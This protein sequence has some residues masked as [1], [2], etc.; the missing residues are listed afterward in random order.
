MRTRLIS[1][2]TIC[3][4]TLG[5]LGDTTLDGEISNEWVQYWQ[6]DLR[7]IEHELPAIHP[8]A[9]HTLSRE[10]FH[11]RID[12]LVKRVADLS[13]E[14]ILLEL[15]KIVS[16]LGDGHTRVTLPL[17][18]NNGL[19]LGHTQTS[20][21]KVPGLEFAV[22]PIRLVIASD[23]TFVYAAH[24]RY[25]KIV[26]AVVE[27]IGNMTI[28]EAKAA[29]APYVHHDNEYQ[30]NYQL[31]DY[32][33]LPAVLADSGVTQSIGAISLVVRMASGKRVTIEIEPIPAAKA[34]DFI[35]VYSGRSATRPLFAQHNERPFW[36]RVLDEQNALYWQYNE[37]VDADDQKLTEFTD[38]LFSELEARA[39]DKLIIDLRRNRGGNNGRNKQILHHLIRSDMAKTTGRV[40]AITGGGTF[41]A[42]M[43]FSV[44][45]EDNLPVVFVGT[46]T[47]SS[48]NHY[49][50]SRKIQ[51][52]HSGITVRVSTLHWQYSDPRDEREAIHPQIAVD[53][54]V[55]D[56]RNGHDPQL[57]AILTSK[58]SDDLLGEWGG[59]IAYR[60]NYALT[61]A[62]EQQ[63]DGPAASISIPDFGIDNAPLTDLIIDGNALTAKLEIDRESLPL[64]ARIAGDMLYGGLYDEY[65]YLPVVLQRIP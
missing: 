44:D 35:D 65:R 10:E 49:G 57:A 47:G 4:V 59:S 32:L 61:L 41:S 16:A 30:L 23:G 21:P 11:R 48:P 12:G 56:Y 54:T 9:F 40:F 14:A 25:A 63:A 52:P 19:F 42:A 55:D 20:A 27:R 18:E 50:D 8:N 43:M 37:V 7:Y 64:D 1:G 51:L 39:I 13:H 38:A 53:F 6:D 24:S 45:L 22:L 26:G 5:A 60:G 17:S 28:D 2:I 46:P 34:S 58:S 15:T 33:I 3:I 29:I 36:Y 31:P 62:I